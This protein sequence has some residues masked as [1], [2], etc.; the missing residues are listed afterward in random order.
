M[1]TSIND[2][3]EQALEDGMNIKVL[4]QA[5]QLDHDS[6]ILSL[7]LGGFHPEQSRD[8]KKAVKE[9]MGES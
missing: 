8:I 7:E 5:S 1:A 6:F 9:W 4:L 2:I 3:I